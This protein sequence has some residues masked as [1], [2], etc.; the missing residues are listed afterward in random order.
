MEFNALNQFVKMEKI[1]GKTSYAATSAASDQFSAMLQ[2]V[3]S[4]NQV[5]MIQPN[6][7]AMSQSFQKQKEEIEDGKNMKAEDEEGEESVYKT[8]KKIEKRLV[9]LARLERQMMAGF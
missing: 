1:H 6:Q 3:V 5:H 4:R 9:A 7:G 8:V 2:S